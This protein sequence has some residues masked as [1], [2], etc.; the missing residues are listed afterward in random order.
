VR[1]FDLL[2]L[3]TVLISQSIAHFP[4]PQPY[5]SK[6]HEVVNLVVERCCVKIGGSGCG[7]KGRPGNELKDTLVIVYEELRRYQIEKGRM[8]LRGHHEEEAV[9]RGIWA[10]AAWRGRKAV[11]S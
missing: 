2:H 8:S 9:V 3:Y 4:A 7:W 6:R 1:Y 5:P 11:K 10:L